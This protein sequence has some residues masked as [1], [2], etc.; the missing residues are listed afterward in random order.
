MT[1]SVYLIC[2]R[3]KPAQTSEKDNSPESDETTQEGTTAESSK[4][5]SQT[6]TEEKQLS[7]S[8][9]TTEKA[10]E[11]GRPTL[12]VVVEGIT[13]SSGTVR[14]AIFKSIAEFKAFDARKEEDKQG[15][16]LRKIVVPVKGT[17]NVSH[18]FTD[19]PPGQYVIA[20]FHDRDGNKK[21]NA[22]LLGLPSE[23]YG[24]SRDARGSLGAPKFED[25]I[26]N[27]DDKNSVFSFKVK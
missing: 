11:A 16:A 2:I 6:A 5:S 19:V 14:I 23:P 4:K 8:L 3:E 26:I 7:E 25:A 17:G 20:A 1:D 13:T 10:V 22:S 24:F 9:P 18:E 15:E 21:L 12:R 27:F